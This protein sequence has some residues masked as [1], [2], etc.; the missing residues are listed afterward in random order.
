[1]E[2]GQEPG[3][4]GNYAAATTSLQV[5]R[6]RDLQPSQEDASSVSNNSQQRIAPPLP[7][8]ARANRLARAAARQ[9]K[10]TKRALDVPVNVSAEAQKIAQA[11]ERDPNYDI[12]EAVTRLRVNRQRGLRTRRNNPIY[13]PL[14]DE[15]GNELNEEH[16][17]VDDAG[18]YD[19]PDHGMTARSSSSMFRVLDRIDEANE[20]DEAA[21]APKRTTG[22]VT[23]SKPGKGSQSNVLPITTGPVSSRKF[24]WSISDT[25]ADTS[26]Q[27]KGPKNPNPTV[28][29]S[30]MCGTC[31]K[32][33]GRREHLKRHERTVHAAEK[34]HICEICGRSYSRSDNLRQHMRVHSGDIGQEMAAGLAERTWPFE[35]AVR[36]QQTT[37]E[38]NHQ[39]LEGI[40]RL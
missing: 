37:M 35:Q 16:Q 27:K 7:G 40:G 13:A 6:T 4:I 5:A 1:V 23:R 14:V 12:D 20:V 3:L 11:T 9:T 21:W 17:E 32:A 8:T 39:R 18:L 34:Q 25:V 29:R 28:D 33:F 2:D 30:F 19:D 22:R 10:L 15:D 36:A 31:P 26:R 38:K 24:S